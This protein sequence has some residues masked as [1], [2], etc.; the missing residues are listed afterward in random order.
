MSTHPSVLVCTHCPHLHWLLRLFVDVPWLTY[1]I[2]SRLLHYFYLLITTRQSR[3]LSVYTTINTTTRLPVLTF[4]ENNLL[5]YLPEVKLLSQRFWSILP[6]W[7]WKGYS[8]LNPHFLML[9]YFLNLDSLL[10]IINKNHNMCF[11]TMMMT[12]LSIKTL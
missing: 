2:Y 5:R 4:S 12:K 6:T 1:P 3:Y 8:K 7:N 10:T 11:S 9:F